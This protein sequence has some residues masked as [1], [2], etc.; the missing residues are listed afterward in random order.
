MHFYLADYHAAALQPGARAVLLDENAHIAEATTA[1][2]LL[3]RQG[4]GLLSPTREHI[5][6]GVSVGVVQELAAKLGVPFQE[7]QL[8]VDDLRTADEAMLTST[9]I[10]LLPIVECN[11]QPMG[12]GQPGPMY[13]RLLAAWSDLAGIDIAEQART[14]AA[15]RS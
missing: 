15:R 6:F 13:R 10:C 4:E 7:R 5:L 8:S 14:I 3:Y 1:N 2:V 12:N 9:S 11:G